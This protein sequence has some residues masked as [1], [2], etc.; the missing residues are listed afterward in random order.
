[1]RD[2]ARHGLLIAPLIAAG[3]T[4][5]LLAFAPTAHTPSADHMTGH[6][7]VHEVVTVPYTP[8]QEVATTYARH[9]R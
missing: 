3:V 6:V 9:A 7:Q 4:C 1:M 2:L 8:A 5:L